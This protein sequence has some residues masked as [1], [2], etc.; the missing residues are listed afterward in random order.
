VRSLSLSLSL[1]LPSRLSQQKEESLIWGIS[2]AL[3]SFPLG[4][5]DRKF[6]LNNNFPL[7]VLYRK[8]FII[9]TR[10]STY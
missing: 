6:F 3:G 2:I 4:C 7:H 1:F 8:M 9:I 10:S 5:S